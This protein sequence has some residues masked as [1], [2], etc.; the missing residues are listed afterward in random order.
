MKKL[1]K[2]CKLKSECEGLGREKGMGEGIISCLRALADS[3]V[4]RWPGVE[5]EACMG[6]L[7]VE[8]RGCG[9]VCGPRL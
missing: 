4:S 5:D 7:V 3:A 8:M 1:R 2:E 9:C 6:G